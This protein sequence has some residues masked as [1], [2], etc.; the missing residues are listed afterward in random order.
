MNAYKLGA[1][2]ACIPIGKIFSTEK[3]YV[4]EKKA[5]EFFNEGI[6]RGVS[7]CYAELAL[8]YAEEGHTDNSI[9]CWNK[10]FEQNLHNEYIKGQ[11]EC[12]YLRAVKFGKIRLIHK[13]VLL[14][15]FD[16]IVDTTNRMIKN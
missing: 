4:D 1:P 11:Y 6:R 16:W 14:E 9:K 8:F 3:G 10:Y 12:E 13:D 15:R 2:E 5:I 7:E